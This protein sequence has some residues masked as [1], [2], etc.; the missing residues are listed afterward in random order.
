MVWLESDGERRKL[1]FGEIESEVG[2]SV[3]PASEGSGDEG[4][5]I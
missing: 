4:E 3:C 2:V 1:P 5:R